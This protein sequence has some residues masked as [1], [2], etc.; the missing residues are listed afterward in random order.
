MYKIVTIL[1]LFCYPL[2]VFYTREPDFQGSNYTRGTI[3]YVTD[4]A[5]NA[6]K[7]IAYFTLLHQE[8]AAKADYLFKKY[9]EAEKVDIIYET[10]NPSNASVYS[11][12][13][14]WIRWKELTSFILIFVV[15]YQVAASLTSN[16][17]PEA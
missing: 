15:L 7:P 11:M 16:P 10:A 2:F 17:T 5:D 9:T 3:H 12:W 4:T 13:G 6:L 8:Y 14:Y 1:F